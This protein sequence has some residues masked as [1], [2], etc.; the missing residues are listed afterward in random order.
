MIISVSMEYTLKTPVS[1]YARCKDKYLICGRKGK[2]ALLW[3][4]NTKEFS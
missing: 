1:L 2:G 3:D 4:L